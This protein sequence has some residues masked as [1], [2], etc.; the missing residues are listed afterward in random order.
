MDV[1]YLFIEDIE[2]DSE[3]LRYSLRSLKNLPHGKVF[4]VGEKP[5]WA[6]NVVHIPVAQTKTKPENVKMNLTAAVNSPDISADFV[7]MNDDFFVMRPVTEMPTLS[8]G[9]M[10][11][12]IAQYDVRY[13][14]GSDYINRMRQLYGVLKE[15]GF[16]R[17]L[18]YELHVPMVLN[19][20]N[21]LQ[22]RTETEDQPIYQFRTYYGN[23]FVLGGTTIKDVK[24]FLNPIHNDPE[25]NNNPDE[26][27]K[28]AHF[29]SATGGSFKHGK[30]GDFI[31]ASFPKKSPYEN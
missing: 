7:L 12:V 8:F 31:R 2:N 26:Y 28:N 4:I 27:L 10:R 13:P 17:P 18:S 14:E 15:R 24:V 16:T 30:P 5:H 6:T 29:L 9:T 22:L 25:Y 23:R 11:E 3:E 1:V 21:I 20:Q 19:K